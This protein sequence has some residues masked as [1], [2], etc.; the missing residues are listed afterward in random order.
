MCNTS[1]GL[2]N[3]FS[4]SL[5]VRA[6]KSITIVDTA[7]IKILFCTFRSVCWGDKWFAICLVGES[8]EL[9]YILHPG[10][11]L[12]RRE[13][14]LS[15]ERHMPTDLFRRRIFDLRLASLFAVEACDKWRV[16]AEK[17]LI[18]VPQHQIHFHNSYSHVAVHFH[19]CYH[20]QCFNDTKL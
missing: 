3:R 9:F 6:N 19:L 17:S 7:E 8:V 12:L 10:G 2:H 1:K 20:H 16:W 4:S 14:P 5:T 11:E 15:E 13:T 18:H